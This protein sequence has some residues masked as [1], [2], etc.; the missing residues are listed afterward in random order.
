MWLQAPRRPFIIYTALQY[1]VCSMQSLKY[2]TNIVTIM[3]VICLRIF[4]CVI[5]Q[6]YPINVLL[7]YL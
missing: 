6:M 3:Y 1:T 7:C 2:F 4:M 5:R